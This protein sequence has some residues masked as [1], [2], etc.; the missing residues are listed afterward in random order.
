MLLLLMSASLAAAGPAD[1]PADPAPCGLE[2][3][4]TPALRTCPSYVTYDEEGNA[5]GTGGQGARH[6]R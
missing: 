5:V 4:A 2:E 1:P 6:D 3:R